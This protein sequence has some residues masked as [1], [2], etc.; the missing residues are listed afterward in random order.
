MK[1]F[2]DTNVI[3]AAFVTRGTC[4]HLFEH[5]LG[6]HVIC[7]SQQVMD[8]LK[9]NLRK[10]LRFPKARV[11]EMMAFVRQNT[12]I[13]TEVHLFSRVCRDPD[14]DNILAV[15]VNGEVDCLITGDED[16]LELEEFQKI[17]ILKPMEFWKFEKRKSKRP[18]RSKR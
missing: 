6:E 5:C 18:R 7:I 10:K 17:P 2:F 13:L 15:A 11:D 14:D 8:E 12:T 3:I 16:L 1:I 4:S 9:R